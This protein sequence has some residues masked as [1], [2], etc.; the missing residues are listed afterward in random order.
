VTLVLFLIVPSVRH[1]IASNAEASR[2]PAA[3]EQVVT[4]ATFPVELGHGSQKPAAKAIWA[5]T[6]FS[7]VS[8]WAAQPQR[9]WAMGRI[10][11]HHPFQKRNFVSV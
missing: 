5:T 10:L 3:S 2:L 9:D 4:M 6:F 7:L 1:L 8:L 11:A